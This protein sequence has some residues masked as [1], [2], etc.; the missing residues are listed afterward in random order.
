MAEQRPRGCLAIPAV[1]AF[2]GMLSLL[3][4]FAGLWGELR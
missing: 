1:I 2:C 4:L 3:F